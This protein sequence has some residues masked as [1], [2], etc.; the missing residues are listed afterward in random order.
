[1]TQKVRYCRVSEFIELQEPVKHLD[2]RAWDLDC[3][4]SCEN[5]KNVIS[6]DASRIGLRD[7]NIISLVTNICNHI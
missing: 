3:L 1:M 4:R 2:L 5:L 6:L 7:D